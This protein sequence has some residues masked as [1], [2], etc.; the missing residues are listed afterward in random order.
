M[1]N[2][3]NHS[4]GSRLRIDTFE[5]VTPMHMGLF[6]TLFDLANERGGAKMIEDDRFALLQRML[7]QHQALEINPSDHY[8]PRLQKLD[9]MVM[10]TTF[11]LAREYFQPGLF[12]MLT[13]TTESTPL[14][15]DDLKSFP[16]MK[17]Y[18]DL[19]ERKLNGPRRGFSAPRP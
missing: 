12:D 5:A 3:F 18:A 17:D 1:E 4:A 2:D 6:E 15:V 10:A 8:L 9:R 11:A 19:F 13:H 7:S 16:E 14:I